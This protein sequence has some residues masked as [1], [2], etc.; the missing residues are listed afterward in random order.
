MKVNTVLAGSA[1]AAAACVGFPA[2]A[3]AEV[4][5]FAPHERTIT[6]EDG[7]KLKLRLENEEWNRVPTTNMTGTSREGYG[8]MRAVVTL[9]GKGSALK[10]VQVQVGYIIGCFADL[11]SVTAGLQAQIGPQASIE[12]GFPIPVVPKG[13]LNAAVT[14]SIQA[15]ISPGQIKAYP[16]AQKNL[17][18]TEGVLQIREAHMNIDGCLGP[19]QVRAYSSVIIDSKVVKDGTTVYGD[20]F[21]I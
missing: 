8:G 20:T 13:A 7:W 11:N 9:D 19:A 16:L 17:E 18:A 14:P 6:T 15:S 2:V 4:L 1:L 10:G 5:T 3:H 21:P 12:P